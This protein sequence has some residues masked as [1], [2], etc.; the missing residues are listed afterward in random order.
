MSEARTKNN[1]ILIFPSCS[2]MGNH[3]RMLDKPLDNPKNIVGYMHKFAFRISQPLNI[4]NVK[5]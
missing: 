2:V 3:F 1:F 4:R 5:K